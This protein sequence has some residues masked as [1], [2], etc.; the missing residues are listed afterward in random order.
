MEQQYQILDNDVSL[1]CVT[2]KSFPDGIQ[3]AF[4]ELKQRIPRNDTRTP[5]G[6]S[7]PERDGTIVYRAGV[8]QA[9]E[10]EAT[11]QGCETVI[12]KKG[13][14]LSRTVTHWQSKMETLGGVFDELI[15]DPRLDPDSLCV[16]IYQSQ[17]ELICM[18]RIK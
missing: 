16:E 9:F 8:E 18:V 12:V 17:T 6:I 5:Y 7:K 10:G 14:Y 2:A 1:L 4:H 13:T 15:R 3:A 11:Q